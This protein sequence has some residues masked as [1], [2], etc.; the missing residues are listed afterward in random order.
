MNTNGAIL[1]LNI[2]ET[3][4]MIL[5]LI[6]NQ[7]WLDC[8]ASFDALVSLFDEC[9]NSDELKLITE[10]INRF[11]YT[12][13][14]DFFNFYREEAKRIAEDTSLLP[15]QC[16]IG[17]TKDDLRP[18]S[19]QAVTRPFYRYL[20][21]YKK[22]LTVCNNFKYIENFICK[23]NKKKI[24]VVLLDDFIGTGRTMIC[25]MKKCDKIVKENKTIEECKYQIIALAAMER[26]KTI[27]ENTGAS[28]Y[29][30]HILR[31][32]ISDNYNG[33]EL[34]RAKT[35]MRRLESLFLNNP[36]THEY[37]FGFQQSEA[38]YVKIEREFTD[39]STREKIF[40]TQKT[41]L[42]LLPTVYY[43]SLMFPTRPTS[44]LIRYKRTAPIHIDRA[45]MPN[46]KM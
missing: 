11:E 28:V 42:F 29:T 26:G 37:S 41:V 14:Q 4:T 40:L 3:E 34:R 13:E 43:S 22:K 9:Q 16:I 19:S 32:G 36:T 25:R 6:K 45:A 35:N 46:A 31:R 39:I 17:P 15:D 30:R 5:K 10:L 38:L 21:P 23:A 1:K 8:R 20:L 7:Y 18:D 2:K 44:G 12:N 33:L 24:N 27:I